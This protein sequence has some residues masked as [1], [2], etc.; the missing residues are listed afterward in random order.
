MKYHKGTLQ[1]GRAMKKIKTI[2][3]VF[4]II[5]IVLMVGVVIFFLINRV[6]IE[7][8]YRLEDVKENQ[9]VMVVYYSYYGS[10][11]M[12]AVTKEGYWKCA[13]ITELKMDNMAL[14][15]KDR[16]DNIELIDEV[17][18]DETIP[19]Q[20]RRFEISQNML[21]KVINIPR[22]KY[23]YIKKYDGWEISGTKPTYTYF[24]ITGNGKNR[25]IVKLGQKGE[26][27]YRF[28]INVMLMIHKL[29]ELEEMR[30][31]VME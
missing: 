29:D 20:E 23:T 26:T 5:G 9:A 6:P 8:K 22:F 11:K 16:R 10:T 24:A 12:A 2:K 4:L 25:K 28:D 27:L 1:G 13:D 21:E 15:V 3:K 31:E 7:K 30:K 14:P 19:Y 18:S 17:M